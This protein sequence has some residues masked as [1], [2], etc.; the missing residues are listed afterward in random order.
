MAIAV[1]RPRSLRV[2]IARAALEAAA[3]VGAGWTFL[4]VAGCL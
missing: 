1:A 4:K 2:R 3:L